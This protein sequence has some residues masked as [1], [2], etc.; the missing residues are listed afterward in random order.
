MFFKK[1]KK[2]EKKPIITGHSSGYSSGYTSMYDLKAEETVVKESDPAPEEKYIW[3]EGYKGT[4][5]DMICT[6][7]YTV[8]H[9]GRCSFPYT[10]YNKTKYELDKEVSLKDN[11]EPI[12]CKKGFHFCLKLEDVF[13]FYSYDFKNRYFKV[14]AYV[15]EKDYN[16]AV[17]NNTEKLVAKKIVLYEEVFPEYE[18]LTDQLTYTLNGDKYKTNKFTYTL[19]KD[20][21]EEVN[22]SKLTIQEV[23][24]K[25][26]VLQMK[27]AG[28]SS[29]FINLLQN[30]YC[31][32]GIANLM[33]ICEKAK[34][35]KEES[36]STDMAVYMLWYEN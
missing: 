4:P 34:A 7:S 35:F 21:F 33:Y 20:L 13:S 18:M 11:E 16:D 3:V 30:K 36:V 8:Y 5:E 10:A 15:K 24:N 17:K 32:D 25:H 2:E 12:L 9:D 29:T 14:R 23:I 28:Y 22:N 1:D 19:S 26:F 6:N 27:E 31:K